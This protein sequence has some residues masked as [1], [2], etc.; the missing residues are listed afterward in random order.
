MIWFIALNP[1]FHLLY[2]G[3]SQLEQSSSWLL[4]TYFSPETNIDTIMNTNKIRYFNL[5]L[6]MIF[7]SI[8]NIKAQSNNNLTCKYILRARLDSSNTNYTSTESFYLIRSQS[9]SVFRSLNGH[10]RDSMML[11]NI[12]TGAGLANVNLAKA[13]RT[14]FSFV[15]IKKE[16][17]TLT[18][19]NIYTSRYFYKEDKELS[20]VIYKEFKNIDGLN[21]Q[22]ASTN[23][24]GR[25]YEAWFSKEIPVSDGPYKFRGLPGLIIQVYD[26]K[27]DYVFNLS[28]ITHKYYNTDPQYR[29][30]KHMSKSDFVSAYNNFRKNAIDILNSR[31][32]NYGN[33]VDIKRNYDAML[34][35]ENNPI[36]L[37]P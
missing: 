23:F 13:P 25:Q 14:K 19:D 18:Y 2:V 7:I 31:G 3:S 29:N 16:G 34:K 21:C 12:K 9:T 35:K 36:E 11:S 27:K 22:K 1:I 10:R 24:A 28:S 33:T 8:N 17:E 20:W 5:I 37:R 30:A 26:I 6:L 15:I 32:K 4:P